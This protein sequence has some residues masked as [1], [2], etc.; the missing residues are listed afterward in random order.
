M[1]GTAT[2]RYVGSM[3]TRADTSGPVSLE[4]FETLPEEDGYFVEVS[5]GHL[6]REPA[7]GDAHGRLVVL[8]AYRLMQYIDQHPRSGTVYAE[9]GFVLALNPLTVRQPDVAFVRPGRAPGGYSPGIF[10]GPP[11]LAVEIVSPSN[12]P[13]E[14]LRKVSELLEAGTALVWVIDPASE[15]VVVHDRSGTP[16]VQR[17]PERLDG[18]QLLPGFSIDLGALFA[19]Y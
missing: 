11:D 8:V 1:G 15:T 2:T 7:P 4:E 19:D 3:M 12:R 9:A 13:G 17:A 18:G 6:V 14:L 5:R 10:R 16:R